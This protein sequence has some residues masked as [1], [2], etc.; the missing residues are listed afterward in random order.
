MTG[1]FPQELGAF[2]ADRKS[3]TLKIVDNSDFDDDVRS[4]EIKDPP[5][6][7]APAAGVEG[8]DVRV[9]I[10]ILGNGGGGGGC[11]IATAAYGDYDHPLVLILRDFRDSFLLE[12]ELGR[13]FVELYYTY[14]PPIANWIQTSSIARILVGL[15]LLPLIGFALGLAHPFWLGLL[16]FFLPARF[17]LPGWKILSKE[18]VL[19]WYWN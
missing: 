3:I 6:P 19:W 16:C 15:T 4:G 13:K 11:F 5:G 14:S 8:P 2:S 12:F 10:G 1:V 17:N 7:G 18:I 9:S